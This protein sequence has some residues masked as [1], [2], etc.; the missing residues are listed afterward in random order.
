MTAL[1]TGNLS[2]LSQTLPRRAVLGTV[3][4]SAWNQALPVLASLILHTGLAVTAMLNTFSPTDMASEPMFRKGRIAATTG[5]N[6][7]LVKITLQGDGFNQGR[8][9]VAP[10]DEA[11]PAAP[12]VVEHAKLP[13]PVREPLPSDAGHALIEPARAPLADQG[14]PSLAVRGVGRGSERAGVASLPAQP[15]ASAMLRATEQPLPASK[16]SAEALSVTH[17]TVAPARRSQTIVDLPKP[18]LPP[19]LPIEPAAISPFAPPLA[20]AEAAKDSH[21]NP[22]EN[23]PATTH[24]RAASQAQASSSPP[25]GVDTGA[26]LEEL[27]TP[28]YP[29]E[30]R[31]R[32]EQGTVLLEIEVLAD[33]SVGAIRVIESPGHPRLVEAAVAAMRRAKLH[34]VQAGAKA[35]TRWIRIPFRFVIR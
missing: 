20:S 30:S 1:S 4:L 21:P 19:A 22:S 12:P 33:G 34:P 8:V 10:L 35:Q 32:G 26:Q 3:S 11:A 18:A 29:A 6:V 5:A 13:Q 24:D 25:A 15:M 23:P 17:V 9:R 31:R 14:G 16:P 28:T 7:R 2:D 27:P